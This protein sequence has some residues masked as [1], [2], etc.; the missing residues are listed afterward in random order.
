MRKSV[1][2]SSRTLF[3]RGVFLRDL[4]SFPGPLFLACPG[5]SKTTEVVYGT[6]GFV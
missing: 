3:F 5:I 2:L 6:F 1:W 4:I